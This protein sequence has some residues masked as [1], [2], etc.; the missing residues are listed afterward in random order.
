MLLKF[1]FGLGLLLSFNFVKAE[2]EY[3]GEYKFE[4][5]N[6]SGSSDCVNYNVILSWNFNIWL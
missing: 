6:L 1:L 5:D 3:Q 4:S 2:N